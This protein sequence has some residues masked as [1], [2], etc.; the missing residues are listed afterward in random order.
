[1]E[2]AVKKSQQMYEEY[3]DSFDRDGYVFIPGFFSAE[4]ITAINQHLEQFIHDS[5][6]AMPA[7]HVMY[8]QAGD[9]STLKQM[10]DLEKHDGFFNEL[11]INS[12]LTQIAESLL[13][14]PVI[15][16]NVE[17][18][19]KPAKIGKATPP[20]Q[21]AFYFNIAPPQAL[22]MWLALEE[23]DQQNG[24]VSYISGS[25]RRGMR[26]HGRTTTLGFSQSIIDYGTEEDFT[27]LHSFPA[28]AGDLLVHHSMTIHSAAPNI[29]DSRSR[30]ALGLIYFGE[31]AKPD[32]EAKAAYQKA[33]EQAI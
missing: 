14:E 12:E 32:A 10:Q 8:E 6:P 7:A 4:R 15:G 25:H 11:M 19:N 5:V 2:G 17:Y 31:S 29:T 21:D 33:L 28:Q 3:K 22:T 30:K 20:H 23:A 27:N 24:C 16:K 26:P 1:L 9:P 18:F 13:G